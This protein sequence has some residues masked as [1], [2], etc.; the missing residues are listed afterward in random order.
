L[1]VY[2]P[3]PSRR[4]G[5]SLGVNN[6]PPKLCSYSCAYCQVGRTS[7]LLVRR[8][9]FHEPEVILEEVRSRLRALQERG[10]TVDYVSFVPD[11]EPTL[12]VHLGESIRR[13]K[14]LGVKVAVISN[15]S[16]IDQEAVRRDLRQADWV[17]LK[18]D[19][20]EERAWRKVNHPER[21]LSLQSILEGMLA[22]TREYREYPGRLVTETMLVP[23][24]NDTAE[25][26][27]QTA[28]ALR[29]LAPEVAYL[30]VP[31]RPPTESWVHMPGE[32]SVLQA[33][34]ILTAA[35]LR[36]EF[37]TGSEGDGF[38]ASGRAEE[39]LLSITAVHPMR[40]PAV[41][42][43]LQR[44]GADWALVQDLLEQDRIAERSYGG[45]VF[46]IRRFSPRRRA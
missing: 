28:V 34:Q 18:L 31:L 23:G 14:G 10:E 12:D 27:Q 5:R 3:V 19:A 38:S 39:D 1:L 25:E 35:G 20:A 41:E 43:L 15:A 6:I 11:G 4:L 45:E 22:F 42:A 21:S 13:I 7:R 16:L 37:L 44:D 30:S 17:S 26:L 40:R 36:V 46:Y 8:Q 24:I 9:K 29:R 33:Y 32:D 2:G